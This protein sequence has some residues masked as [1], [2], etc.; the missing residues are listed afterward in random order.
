MRE[1]SLKIKKRPLRISKGIKTGQL[2]N[3]NIVRALEEKNVCCY[4]CFAEEQTRKKGL[5]NS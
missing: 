5:Q 4:L 2:H 1:N 3:K